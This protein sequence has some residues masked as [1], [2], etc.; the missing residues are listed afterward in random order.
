MEAWNR[1]TPKKTTNVRSK[2][3]KICRNAPN[4]AGPPNPPTALNPPNPLSH[5]IRIQDQE[6]RELAPSLISGEEVE[7]GKEQSTRKRRPARRSHPTAFTSAGPP[8]PHPSP[9]W[10]REAEE[11]KGGGVAHGHHHHRLE[12]EAMGGKISSSRSS[13]AD[14]D[15]DSGA[16]GIGDF[17]VLTC[18]L[19]WLHVV[20]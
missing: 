4:L 7:E 5:C 13:S 15:T 12:V 10:C 3:S 8:S 17:A 1:R 18:L 16:V 6:T 20:I 19:K 2:N 14:A 9:L 11:E